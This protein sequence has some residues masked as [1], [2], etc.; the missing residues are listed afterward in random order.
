MQ[1]RV[2]VFTVSVVFVVFEIGV[3]L[4]CIGRSSLVGEAGFCGQRRDMR[5]RS[6]VFVL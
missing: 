2:V 5:I 4:V 1:D 3:Y 6:D